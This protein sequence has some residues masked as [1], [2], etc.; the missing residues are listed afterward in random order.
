MLKESSASF[1]SETI[2]DANIKIG[3]PVNMSLADGKSLWYSTIIR[4]TDSSYIMAD[5]PINNKREPLTLTEG[6]EVKCKFTSFDGVYTFGTR[7]KS[8]LPD[9][10]LVV[11]EKPVSVVKTEM[12]EH[13]RLPVYKQA[14]INGKHDGIVLNLS[15][16]GL[17]LTVNHEFGIEDIVQLDFDL[18]SCPFQVDGQ[19]VRLCG[20][21]GYGIKFVELNRAKRIALDH[22]ILKKFI[23]DRQFIDPFAVL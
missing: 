6:E 5:L 13:V 23:A 19:V 10:N 11:L 15:E 7:F 22:Y 21:N 14:K 12:R 18:D 9:L 2:C 17:L 8:F 1:Y 4:L 20:D 3:T 16:G